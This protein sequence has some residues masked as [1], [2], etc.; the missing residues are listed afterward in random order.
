VTPCEPTPIDFNYSSV[1]GRLKEGD[2]RGGK[3]LGRRGKRE[4]R[5]AKN[6]YE[7][8][9]RRGEKKERVRQELNLFSRSS[10]EK[11]G[12]AGGGGEREEGRRIFLPL[13][14]VGWVG[15]DFAGGGGEKKE[16]GGRRGE[17]EE[18]GESIPPAGGIQ[19]AL[20]GSHAERGG[21]KKERGCPKKGKGGK[22]EGGGEK[23]LS[24]ISSFSFFFSLTA[25]RQE[26]RGE[27]GG[28]RIPVPRASSPFSP[29]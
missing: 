17:G 22:K 5:M 8:F 18:N 24:F 21:K 28:G 26:G 7:F 4:G 27:K 15:E 10:P 19:S 13:S 9:P 6:P 29:C 1:P 3:M 12:K 16:R 23:N 25:G 11:G 2:E 14:P 20:V